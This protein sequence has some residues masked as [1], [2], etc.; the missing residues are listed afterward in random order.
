MKSSVKAAFDGEMAGASAAEAAG[1]FALAKHHLERAHILGQC[2]Y[3]AHV[4]THYRMLRLA[5]RQSDAS[6][7]RGQ[8]VR[9]VGAGPFHMA[10]W[11]PVG[12]TGGADVSATLPM[13]IP[14]DLAQHLEDNPLRKGLIIRALFLAGLVAAWLFFM[15]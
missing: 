9:L 15:R 3:V 14:S 4:K 7:A 13:P 2:W 12:N 5:L 10:G 6:E 11:V 8:L 1:D